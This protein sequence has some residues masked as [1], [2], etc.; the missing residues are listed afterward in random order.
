MDISADGRYIVEG[1]WGG[2]IYLFSVDSP[3]PLWVYPTADVIWSVAISQDGDFIAAAGRTL[4]FFRRERGEPLWTYRV[5]NALAFPAVP[6]L[7]ANGGY[8]VVGDMFGVHLLR[9]K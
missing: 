1:G 4:Y 2:N 6:R 5:S 3:N 8:V 7:S 9:A